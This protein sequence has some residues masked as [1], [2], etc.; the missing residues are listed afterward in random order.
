MSKKAT[1]V[2][3]T[4][5]E[6]CIKDFF[7]RWSR[8]P[9]LSQVDVIVVED[10]PK[11]TFSLDGY[12]V[13]EHISWE[14]ID[15]ELEERSWIIPRRSDC[16]R[17][18]GYYMAWARETP[19]VLTLD[20]DCYPCNEYFPEGEG[21]S[22]LDEH[23]AAIEKKSRWFS[24][25]SGTIRPR[26]IPYFNRGKRT[27]IVLNHGLWTNVPD[28]DAPHQLVVSSNAFA[29]RQVELGNC[30]D[31]IARGSYFPMC[32]MNVCWKREVTVLMYH[33]LMGKMLSMPNEFLGDLY[34][35][36]DATGYERKLY[37]LPYDR[38]GDIWSGIVM[39]KI[40]DELGFSVS[41]GTPYIRH[42]RASDPFK[43]LKKEANGLETNEKFWEH[44]DRWK[45]DRAM[46]L[47]NAYMSMGKHVMAFDPPDQS[48][49]KYFMH[50]G[51]AMVEWSKMFT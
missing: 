37:R 19:Y 20:D 29:E 28:L 14:Q 4:I 15:D 5:R 12:G 11:R 39:K 42:E 2:V 41:S 46:T 51:T 10:N 7:D 36:E 34:Q 31:V 23:V 33:M 27:D 43:N 47:P 3:P 24:T 8:T 16:V 6:K 1:L 32:G 13:T 9:L 22:L 18:Y 50:L 38:M 17:S 49:K 48:M 44:V 45:A 25:L 26:G 40:V 21:A 35:D 30:N